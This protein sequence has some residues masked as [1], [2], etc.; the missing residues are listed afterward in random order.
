VAQEPVADPKMHDGTGAR[1][2]EGQSS[3]HGCKAMA[4]WETT[5]AW[6]RQ[7]PMGDVPCAI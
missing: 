1:N 4:V 5:L 3:H 2:I 7:T 6:G